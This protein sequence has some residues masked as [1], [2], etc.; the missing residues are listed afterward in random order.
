ME[1]L[2]SFLSYFWEVRFHVAELAVQHVLLSLMGV[3]VGTITALPL[4]IFATRYPKIGNYAVDITGMLYTVPS[5][6]ILGFMLPF[7]GLGWLPTIMALIIYS[8]MPVLRNTCAGILSVDS[9]VKEAAMGMG[10]TP[11]QVLF[12]V[13]LPLAFPVIMAG[14]RTVA[15]LTI[16]VATMGALAGAGGLGE[17]VFTGISMM[18]TNRTL[19]G[20]IPVTIMALLADQLMGLIENRAK[21]R[22]GIRG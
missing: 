1:S 14:V 20:A 13:E 22:M 9:A 11:A 18:D 16:G 19:V 10:A 6:A 2:S 5:L 15:V 12:R 21:S 3:I 17:L 8:W 4:G 7:L